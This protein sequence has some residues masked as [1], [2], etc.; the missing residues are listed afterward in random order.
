MPTPIA[1]TGTEVALIVGAIC[2]GISS[3]IVA[4]NTWRTV[5]QVE[6]VHDVAVGTATTIAH[7]AQKADIV[8]SNMDDQLKIIHTLTN[9][10]LTAA[11]K[12]IHELETLQI[13]SKLEKAV[14]AKRIDELESKVRDLLTKLSHTT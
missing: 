12:R 8:A 5:G 11:N 9:S 7:A 4:T 1:I 10:T 3:L 2:T 14:N 13:A 6:K